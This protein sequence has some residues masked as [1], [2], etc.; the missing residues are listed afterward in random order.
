MIYLNCFERL[1][2]EENCAE[3]IVVF[4]IF[5]IWYFSNI[6]YLEI[7]LCEMILVESL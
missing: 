5:S 1:S 6:N 3:R 2:R 4:I 7:N